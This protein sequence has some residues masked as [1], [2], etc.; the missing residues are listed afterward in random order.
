MKTHLS[1]RLLAFAGGA[2]ALLTGPSTTLAASAPDTSGVV[3]MTVTASVADNK[4]MPEIT[5]DDIVVRQGKSRLEVADWTPA[6]GDRAGLE[7]FILIDESADPRISLLYD[8]LRQF[9]SSQPGSTLVGVGYMRNATVQIAQDLT[10]DHRLA[11]QSL[12]L[13]I[14]HPMAYGSP[15]LSVSSLMKGW[16]PNGNRREVI[17]LTDGIG[18][19]RFHRFGWHN[20]Y[21]TDPDADTAV[22]V[23]QRT[24]TNI[25]TMYVPGSARGWR[26][27]WAGLNGQ[28]NM[29]RLSDS[30]GG[31]AFFLGLHSPVTISPYLGQV[32]KMLDNQYILSFIAKPGKKAGLQPI[33]LSTEVAGVDLAAHNA[34][35]VAGSR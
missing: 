22:A 9:I 2:I 1:N 14:G 4:R 16:A 10:P 19:G 35:W 32:Q 30:T 15:Y 25:F 24:G 5:G 28:F 7:L 6:R 20:S 31:S 21:R 34:V 27:T 3:T 26:G 8:D 33:T 17:M 23:A 18:R 13:P 11:S 29:T 12:R